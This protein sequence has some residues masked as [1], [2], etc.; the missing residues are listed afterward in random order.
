MF[1][2][3]LA[4]VAVAMV[5]AACGGTDP[6]QMTPSAA[7]CATG[8]GAGGGGGGGTGGGGGGGGGSTSCGAD[9]WTNY[10]KTWFDGNCSGCH[11]TEFSTYQA[12]AGAQSR[13]DSRISSGSMPPGG[14]SS[15]DRQRILSWFS[16]NMPQ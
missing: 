14:L 1:R 7:G 6:C 15:S 3:R 10:A 13:I 11:S 16:C 12:V 2:F 4:W 9:T 8:G 5:L